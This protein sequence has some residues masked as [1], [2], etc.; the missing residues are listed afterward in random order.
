MFIN[1]KFS[2]ISYQIRVDPNNPY[3]KFYQKTSI[4][5]IEIKKKQF[6]YTTWDKLYN[7]LD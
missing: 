6:D 7:K 2:F 3:A 5:S 1:L 4:H